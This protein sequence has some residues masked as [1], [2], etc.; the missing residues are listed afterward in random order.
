MPQISQIVSSLGFDSAGALELLH[1][2]HSIDFGSD[3]STS[4]NVR[5]DD[6]LSMQFFLDYLAIIGVPLKPITKANCSAMA[7]VGVSFS[8]WNASYSGKDMFNLSFELGH[9]TF[10]IARDSIRMTW[11]IVFHPRIPE[12]LNFNSAKRQRAQRK[13]A[14]KS[15]LRHYHAKTLSKYIVRIFLQGG[16]VN[17]GVDHTWILGSHKRQQIPLS[18]WREFQ[19]EFIEGW[20]KFVNDHKDDSFWRTHR[21]T[22]HCYDYGANLPI[23]L[24][25]FDEQSVSHSTQYRYRDP[26]RRENIPNDREESDLSSSRLRSTATE[27]YRT[28][29]L[30][31]LVQWDL[32]C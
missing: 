11:F 5:Y 17:R 30:P 15:A 2:R 24:A 27:R 25:D 14:D 18:A 32:N 26:L 3:A 12:V 23:K 4:R 28:N 6:E 19:V 10:Q 29:S 8:S 1:T 16:L 21:P 9:R 31:S 20:D 13:A 22:F 7:H